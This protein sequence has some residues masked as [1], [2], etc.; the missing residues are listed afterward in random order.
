[1][2]P[3]QNSTQIVIKMSNNQKTINSAINFDGIHCYYLTSLA[4]NLNI[5]AW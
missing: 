3:G 5:Y 2:T 4:V 1:M